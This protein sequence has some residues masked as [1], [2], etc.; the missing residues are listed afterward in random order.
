MATLTIDNFSCIKTARFEMAPVTVLIGPQG[1]GKSVTTKLFYFCL[2]ALSR[3][4]IFAEKGQTLEEFQKDTAKHFKTWFPAS[5]WGD[6]RFNIT[7]QSGEFSVRLLRKMSKSKPTDEISVKFSDF[8]KAHYA[9]LLSSYEKM[10][11]KEIDD[12]ALTRRSEGAWRIR[13]AS[14]ARLAKAMDSAYIQRQTFIPAGRAF[15]TSVGRL[16]AALDQGSSLDP[17]NVRF[18][19][20]FANFRDI[21]NRHGIFAAP[22]DTDAK[23]ARDKVMGELF[24]GTIKF[25]NDLEFIEAPDGRIIPFSALSSGQQELLPMWLMIDFYA[26]RLP[27][28]GA[29]GDLFYIEEPEAHLFPSAQSRLMDVLISH[30]VSKKKNRS[31]ILTTHSPYILSNI[32]NY[33]KAGELGRYRKNASAVADVVDRDLWLTSS[34]VK[35]YAIDDGHLVDIID[36]D[37]GLINASYI[38]GVSNEASLTFSKLL[39]IEY[40]EG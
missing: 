7:F 30:L 23:A 33:I 16:V 22:K 34:G 39:D 13:E 15:Y 1:S 8:F 6:S 10:R 2:D 24:G 32:N 5:A 9:G 21:V 28:S 20:L 18:A 29:A 31:L 4:Y 12:E 35:A 40:P 17:I 19:R 3:Q 26:D 38:D 37:D 25:E 11:T 14:H 27:G 36:S